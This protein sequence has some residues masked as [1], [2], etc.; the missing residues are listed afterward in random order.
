MCYVGHHPDHIQNI[1]QIM[2]RSLVLHVELLVSC[3]SSLDVSC[4]ALGIFGKLS[5]FHVVLLVSLESSR[6]FMLRSWYLWKALDVSCCALDIFGK[7][8]MFHVMLFISLESSR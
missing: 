7:L 2:M 4:C 5:M 8:S 3:E 1:V 6:C